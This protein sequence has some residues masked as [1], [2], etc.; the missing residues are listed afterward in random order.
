VDKLGSAGAFAAAAAT[1]FSFGGKMKIHSTRMINF[2]MER[3]LEPVYE[4]EYYAEFRRTP[5]LYE[6]LDSYFIVYNCFPNR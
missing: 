1:S 5:K 6:L 4:C 2:L 3:G